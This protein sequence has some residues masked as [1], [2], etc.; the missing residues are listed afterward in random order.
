M[1][2]IRNEGQISIG[3]Q[4]NLAGEQTKLLSR[5]RFYSSELEIKQNILIGILLSSKNTNL[6]KVLETI[7]IFNETLSRLSDD[8]MSSNRLIF[9][10]PTSNQLKYFSRQHG[11][12]MLNLVGFS[13]RK[14]RNRPFNVLKYVYDSFINDFNYFYFSTDRT[15]LNIVQMKKFLRQ[16]SSSHEFLYVGKKVVG[17]SSFCSLGMFNCN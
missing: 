3:N 6:E 13:E 15:F 16:I 8:G 1:F 7:R 11:S 5:P 9:F 2:R 17:D 12:S 10:L 14:D 4:I